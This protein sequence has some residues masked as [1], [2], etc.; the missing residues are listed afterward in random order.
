MT[1]AAFSLFRSLLIYSICVPLALI[2]GYLISTPEDITSFTVVGL[3]LFFLLVPLLLR[4]HHVWLIA[5]WNMSVVLFFLSTITI[6]VGEL[7]VVV[8]PT[9]YFLFMLFPVG[10]AGLQAI[11]FDPTGRPGFASRLSGLASAGSA[12]YLL[13]LCRYGIENLFSLRRL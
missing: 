1:T 2:L 8:T 9:F 6:A 11:Y 5:S 3:V 12:L 13:M 4:W 10:S 7:A